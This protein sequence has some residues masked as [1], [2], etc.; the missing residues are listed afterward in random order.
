[1]SSKKRLHSE[2]SNSIHDHPSAASASS[3][4]SSPVHSIRHDLDQV[5][6]DLEQVERRLDSSNTVHQ[7]L[8]N[9]MTLPG[10]GRAVFDS[11]ASALGSIRNRLQDVQTSFT[12]SLTSNPNG[13]DEATTMMAETT[14]A[15]TTA[16][17]T[18]DE[19]NAS[20][21]VSI[22]A[23]SERLQAAEMAHSARIPLG[24]LRNELVRREEESGTGSS[25]SSRS[26]DHL[27]R[28]ES[29]RDADNSNIVR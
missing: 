3:S 29:E 22:G 5:R 12:N 17:N 6:Q 9:G 10:A 16:T 11:I 18:H 8:P 19:T 2:M 7:S 13:P 14:S 20:D 1:M 27:K 15:A 24:M 23:L 4:P 26:S 25:N 21:A 28:E